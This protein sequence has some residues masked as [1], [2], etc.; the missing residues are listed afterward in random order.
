MS[1]DI[2]NKKLMLAGLFLSKFNREGLQALGFSTLQ[3]A[4]NSFAYL[5]GGKPASVK[6]Y[7]QEFDPFFPNSRKGWHKRPI[8]QTRQDFLDE[9]GTLDLAEFVEL[10][11]TQFSGLNDVDLDVDKAIVRAG[12]RKDEDSTFARRLLTGQAAENYFES[13]YRRV[14]RFHDC[15]LSRT[16][17]YGCGFDFKLTPQRGEFYAVEVKGLRTPTGSVQLTEKEYLM[18]H[19]LL[20]RYFLYVV[21]DFAHTPKPVVIENPIDSG[22]EFEK[23]QVQSRQSVWIAKIAG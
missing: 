20:A 14:E 19:H 10:I 21:T 8:R 13:N 3:E 17:A 4:Y 23:R 16:T 18:A 12:L 22:I 5:V 1:M 11:R 6:L 15:I 9:F 2:A 7:M